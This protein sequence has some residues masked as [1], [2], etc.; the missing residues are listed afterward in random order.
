VST[1]NDRL[2]NLLPQVIRLRDS[3]DPAEPLRS[4]LS[5]ISEQ[6][7]LLEANV[8]QL[9]DDWFIETCQD[10]IVPYI[11]DL[12]GYDVLH[13]A[14]DPSTGTTPAELGLDRILIPRADVGNTIGARRRKGTLRVLVDLA[15]DVAGWPAVAV[16]FSRLTGITQGLNDLRSTRGRTV[17]VRDASA[18]ER[19]G[20]VADTSSRSANLRGPGPASTGALQTSG[21]GLLI[22]R[23][24]AYSVSQSTAAWIPG[25]GDHGFTFSAL[26]NDLPLYSG[27]GLPIAL[28]R[29]DAGSEIHYGEGK[30]LAI[31][32]RAEGE[33]AKATLV[34]RKRIVPANLSRWHRKPS[35]GTVAVDAVLGRISFPPDE[36]PAQVIV[37]YHYG[38]SY[39]I[40]AGE[41]ERLPLPLPPVPLTAAVLG[42]T[43][44]FAGACLSGIEVLVT[45]DA[46]ANARYVTTA[47]D[48]LASVAAA[49]AKAIGAAAIPGITASATDD[50]VTVSG[51]QS[52]AVTF[53]ERSYAIA[54]DGT[55]AHERLSRALE[56]W[57]ADGPARAVIEFGD[58]EIYDE[59]EIAIDLFEG[60]VL[61][62]RAAGGA[63]PVI[64]MTEWRAGGTE[65][66]RLGGAPGSAIVLDGLIVAGSSL[67]IGGRLSR[68]VLRSSTLV[69]GWKHL[70]P[71]AR[72]HRVEPSITVEDTATAITI[73]SS[74]VGPIVV[75]RDERAAVST[76]ISIAD[77]IVDA[78][79]HGEAIGS[80]DARVANVE[81]RVARSTI[82]GRVRVHAVAHA[83]NSIFDREVS[84]T[85]R[86][87]GCFRYSYVP[88][89]SRTPPRYACQPEHHDV[90]V[91]FAS[92]RYDD[93]GY[94]RLTDDAPHAIAAGAD[95]RSEMGAFHDLY[96]PERETNLRIRLAEYTPAGTDLALLFVS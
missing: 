77:S 5:V 55:E 71:S 91:S 73:E 39:E 28:A 67:R 52:L 53:P 32:T 16:E 47:K 81:L 75:R 83:E 74:I 10:W 57:K 94:A 58:S 9:Y 36:V 59:D 31:W 27:V 12:I 8:A 89:G 17:N 78:F 1:P 80:P 68:L 82:F 30:S 93:P 50:V 22:P 61:Q 34:T 46:V 70:S 45:V 6:A 37:S 42:G 86:Q 49:V 76:P 60:Q 62:I 35:P 87:H 2:Y 21:V 29:A 84:V 14:G 4:L 95:D 69:P 90:T 63:R 88:R 51:S 54:H 56:R 96:R 79:E 43:I 40:G 25:A 64:R 23:Y 48:S 38:F 41:Y 7:D 15:R 26:G 13:A 72:R 19:I 66:I 33:N 65:P 11:G 44:T 20:S 24:R 85:D 92:T 18:L 3:Q